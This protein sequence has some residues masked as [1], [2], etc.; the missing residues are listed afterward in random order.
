[1]E[2]IHLKDESN[3]RGYFTIIPNYILN[4]ST[5]ID[6]A[7][8]VQMKRLAGEK[9]ECFASRKYF[10]KQLRITER[11]F[12]KSL[13]YLIDHEWIKFVGT[14]KAQTKGGKQKMNCYV[15]LDLW[16]KNKEFYKGGEN[17]TY[18]NEKTPKGG[19][20]DTPKGGENDTPKK[21]IIIKEDLGEGEQAA[22]AAPT[23]REE[24]LEFLKSPEAQIQKLIAARGQAY[25]P[26]IRK[27]VEAFIGHWTERTAS[28]KKQRWEME[29]T[30]ELSRRLATW[31]RNAD[32]WGKSDNLKNQN[33][34]VFMKIN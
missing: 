25:E 14:R 21:N 2:K 23:P 20:N 12:Y 26:F 10:C 18:L 31:F 19:E 29:K 5:A 15:M 6:Q 3:D 17:D 8:Y 13:K 4:H 27:E 22:I 32:K 24:F 28:G 9:G 30:F 1:M 7:L 34:P 16:H 33:R 11:T